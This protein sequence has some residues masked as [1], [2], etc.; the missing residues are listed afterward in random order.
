MLVKQKMN[1]IFFAG[2][3]IITITS[4]AIE[5]IIHDLGK[6]WDAKHIPIHKI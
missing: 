6:S 5:A 4:E 3:S 2:D 1:S